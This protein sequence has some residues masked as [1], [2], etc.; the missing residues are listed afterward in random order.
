[1]SL[2]LADL[3]E[4]VVDAVPER[5]ALVCGAAERTFAELDAGANRFGHHLA[6]S[7]ISEGDHVGLHMRNSIEYIE[8][9][10]GCLKVRA[11]PVNIN[12]RYV[13]AELAYLYVDADLSCVVAD[14][15]F[16]DVIAEVLPKTDKLRHVVLLG[17]PAGP[18]LSEA[19]VRRQ[20]RVAD[21]AKSVTAESPGR[22]FPA[23]SNDDLFMIYTGGTTGMPKGVMWRHE[24]FFYSALN[25]GNPSGEPFENGAQLGAAAAA[26]Q[27]ALVYLST[28][29]LMHGGGSFSL[30]TILFM[31]STQIFLPRFDP[32]EVVR[33][34]D[35]RRVNSVFVVGDAMG[36]PLADAIA[37]AGDG[38]DLTS[39]WIIASGG[40]LWSESVRTQLQTLLP[41]VQLRNGFGSSESGMDGTLEVDGEGRLRIPPSPRVRV[42]DTDFHPIEPGSGEIGYLAHVG[43]V[44]IG[45]YNDPAKSAA[46][47]PVVDGIRLS[48]AGDLAQVLP[49]GSILV[50]GRGSSCI[51]SGGEK[52]YAEEVEQAV[53]SH[54]A[55]LD[56]VVAGTPDPRFGQRVSAVIQLRDGAET[57]DH[58]DL[59]AHCREHIAGYKIPRTVVIVP[60]IV[61][62][63]SGKA[64]YR[65][66]RM[67]LESAG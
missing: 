43:H 38:V 67:I 6:A 21:W 63:A 19:A 42:V 50:L 47:F 5:L 24:D 20:V 30:F 54:P 25:G 8:A 56:A 46:T 65:W 51:N 27:N 35:E 60:E 36:R 9:M 28:A 31:G 61:R 12:F 13:G 23:R 39:L 22:G 18:L 1:M 34:V 26:D 17:E 4:A 10:L 58:G 45:Y 41:G 48:I 3:L 44:P 53:K 29:P 40:A 57:P 49:D 62:S 37:R 16:G 2:N 14:G 52:V 66:A 11:V 55:V 59:V 15:E 7:G 64:D 33:L 32:A